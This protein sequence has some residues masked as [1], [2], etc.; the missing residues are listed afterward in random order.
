MFRELRMAV[1]RTALGGTPVL[2]R[3]L[4]IPRVCAPARKP[5]VNDPNRRDEAE[6]NYLG[7]EG[8]DSVPY[9]SQVGGLGE[10]HRDDEIRAQ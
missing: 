1:N 9:L 2:P 8:C 10:G 3:A 7:I 4:R 5:L 6:V